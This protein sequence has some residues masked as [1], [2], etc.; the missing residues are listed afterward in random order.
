M[1]PSQQAMMLNTAL[2]F[3]KLIKNPKAGSTNTDDGRIQ[4]TW[5]N[6]KELEDYITKLQS[7]ADKLMSENRLLRKCHNNIT[8]KVTFSKTY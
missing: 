1:I 8:E 3:E 4:I 6:P 7:A 5:D 2:S